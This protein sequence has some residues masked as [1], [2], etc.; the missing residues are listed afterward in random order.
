MDITKQTVYRKLIRR[1]LYIK[2]PLLIVTIS[3]YMGF[4]LLIAYK[5]QV[6]SQS[7]G[8]SVISLGLVLGI[9]LILIILFVTALYAVL[10]NKLIEPLI[11]QLRK[12]TKNYLIKKSQK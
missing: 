11:N 7:L 1:S 8:T 3:A 12:P 9:C 4:I 2:L 5:P 6:L 10:T